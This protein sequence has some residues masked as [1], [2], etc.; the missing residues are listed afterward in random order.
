MNK[1]EFKQNLAVFSAG[2]DSENKIISKLHGKG[3]KILDRFVIVRTGT[4]L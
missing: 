3:Q 2:I 1:G 4:Y